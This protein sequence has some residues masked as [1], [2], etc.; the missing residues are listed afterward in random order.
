MPCLIGRA[1]KDRGAP[2]S[3][4]Y[5]SQGPRLN[6]VVQP[7]DDRDCIWVRPTDRCIDLPAAAAAPLQS[8]DPFWGIQP[9][10]LRTSDT[11]VSSLSEGGNTDDA[12]FDDVDV[13]ICA[14]CFHDLAAACVVRE[15][16]QYCPP[17]PV[18]HVGT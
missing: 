6:V 11:S 9:A 13:P 7:A 5:T 2:A 1:A 14:D 8:S 4:T 17:S 12:E 3:R 15:Q 18:H 16:P 10:G